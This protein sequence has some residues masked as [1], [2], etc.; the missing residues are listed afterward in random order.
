[1]RFESSVQRLLIGF[2]IAFGAVML[3]A[4]YW[5]V[6]GPETALR[7]PINN[8]RLA[9]AA[10]S[11]IRGQIVD[12]RGAVL[13]ESVV[14]EDNFVTRR[15]TDPSLYSLTGY[16]SRR[17]GT[18]GA[19]AAYD[20][21]LRGSDLDDDLSAALRHDLLHIPRRGYDIRLTIDLAV[22]QA[23]AN[24]L[25][26]IGQPGGAAVIDGST[27]QILAAVSVPSV[28]PDTLDANWQTLVEDPN[29]P[30]L[31]RATQGRYTPGSALSL[32]VIT[33]WLIDG[34]SLDDVLVPGDTFTPCTD[35]VPYT[36]RAAIHDSCSAAIYT[37]ATLLG[38]PK[39]DATAELFGL[40][41]PV[42][43]SGF[44]L[45]TTTSADTI[46]R[47]ESTVSPEA[48]AEA[49]ATLA[50]TPPNPIT[51]RTFLRSPLELAVM[52][53][54]IANGGN[55]MQPTLLAATRA[56]DAEWLSAA[57]GGQLM[58]VTTR[59]R[60]AQVVAAMRSSAQDGL[61]HSDV[62][63]GTDIGAL[64]GTSITSDGI[65]QA[66]YMGFAMLADG[67]TVATALAFEGIDLSR[68][69]DIADAGNSVLCAA[70][71]VFAEG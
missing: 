34:R 47:P 55:A 61:A 2:L 5:T 16:S 27:G 53:A 52:V 71:G 44:T 33:A 9:D 58:A 45:P 37:M 19:E 63:A 32:V 70:L 22:Q 31:N 48:T 7:D 20:A 54:A 26:T 8:F 49:T 60:A 39:F 67:H 36:V 57:A 30:F 68:A 69:Q 50:Q 18:G 17:Y 66:F 24:A 12:R 41:T 38:Q 56:P 10:A 65:P 35:T 15:T 25:V 23:A 62:C 42:V 14:G 28:D 11:I 59:Q 21:L 1:M 4:V 40:S 6:I 51:S 3:S 29:T 43:V 64:L 13:V 46:L